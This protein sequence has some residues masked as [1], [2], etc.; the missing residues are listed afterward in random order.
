MTG[1]ETRAF[2]PGGFGHAAGMKPAAVLQQLILRNPPL[3]LAAAE[4]LTCGHMQAQIGAVPGASGYFLGGVTAYTLEQKVNLLGVNRAHA[5]AVDCV[6]QRVAVEMAA[7]AAQL[8][9][10]DLAVATTGYAQPNRAAGIKAPMAWW[11]LCHRRRGGLAVVISGQVKVPGAARVAV[12]ERV[13][14]VVLQELVTYLRE[15]RG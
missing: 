9:G 14:Q 5:R 4:S 2:L 7:G 8:F 15:W 1:A 10:A 3:T 12:Q 11:A 13:A 6:S